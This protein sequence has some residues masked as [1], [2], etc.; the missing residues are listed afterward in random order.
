MKLDALKQLQAIIY[1]NTLVNTV[2]ERLAQQFNELSKLVELEA[3]LRQV[4]RDVLQQVDRLTAQLLKD[5]KVFFS[6]NYSSGLNGQ[7]IQLNLFN[8]FRA[9]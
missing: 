9:H 2:V 3:G 8:P 6:K 5:L 4:L 1:I 7:L